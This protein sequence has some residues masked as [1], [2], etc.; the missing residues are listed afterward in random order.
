MSKLLQTRLP[1]STTDTVESDTYNRLVRVLEINL[2]EVDPDNIRQIS[3]TDR[4]K[5]RFNEGSIIWNTDIGALQVFTGSYWKTVSDPS[6]PTGVEGVSAVGAVTIKANGATS[7]TTTTIVHPVMTDD[8]LNATFAGGITATTGT[9]SGVLDADAGITVDNITIDGTEIDLSSG[10]LSIDVA[11]NI[12]LDADDAGE[13]R[14]KDGGTHFATIKKDGNNALIQSIV[15]DGDLVFQGIDG[16]SW[17]TP[18]TFDMSEGGNPTFSGGQSQ[19]ISFFTDSGSSQGDTGLIFKT[20][21]ASANQSIAA[22]YAQQGSGDGAARK[23]EMVFQVADN[24][25]P[26]T[27]WLIYNN[28]NAFLK[29]FNIDS[30]QFYPQTDN[31]LNLGHPSYRYDDIYATN[32]TIQT[33]DSREKTT[34]TALTTNEIN[35]SK[36][37]AKEFGTYKWLSA[38]SEKGS[39]ART[40]IGITAQKVKEIMETNSLDPT[41][42][43]FYCYDEWD[44]TEEETIT[45]EEGGKEVI[46]PAKVAGNRYGIRYSEL[47]AFIVAGFNA[48]LTA[49]EES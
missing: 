22:I 26:A 9:F 16:S 3:T 13:V 42:Y 4:D 39:N 10:D 8:G 38:V 5:V 18:L 19:T 49:L 32:T 2:G 14:F 46:K 21:G 31:S 1:I 37:L 33:S 36:A 25:T 7:I 17:V 20:D 45:T 48:R 15:A 24:S 12:T 43:A 40:H 30:A 29:Y 27:A 23:G 34:L 28:G 11:G 41:K 47:Y 35:A 44:A 6:T